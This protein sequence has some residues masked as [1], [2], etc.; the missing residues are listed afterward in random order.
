MGKQSDAVK[1]LSGKR[2]LVTGSSLGIGRAVAVRLAAEGAQVVLSARHNDTLEETVKLIRD[3]GGETV[4]CVG[5][6]ADY[7]DAGD[8]VAT[9]VDQFGGIDVLINCAGI[10]EPYGTSIVNIDETDWRELIDVHLHGTFNTC[11]HAAPLMVQ[12]GGGTIINTSS[13]A[14]LG[15]YGGTGYAAGKGGVNSLSYAMATDLGEYGINVNVVC[16][17]AKTRLS[18]GDEYEKKIVSLHAK[19]ILSDERKQSALNP[20]SPDYVASLYALLASDLARH[21]SGQVFWGSGGY[22][23]RFLE[24]GQEILTTLDPTSRPPWGIAKLAEALDL[25]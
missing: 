21:V 4:A 1:S 9:C 18:T 22:I 8:M 14:F 24:N 16:P 5:S 6:V 25:S 12:Q 13:H 23:G 20:A 15:I 7:G 2:A 3:A 17:G 11:R 10:A 19:G